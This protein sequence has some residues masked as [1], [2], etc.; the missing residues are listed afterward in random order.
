MGDNEILLSDSKRLYQKL[1]RDNVYAHIEV[2]KGMWHVFQMA[3]FR[4][5]NEAMDKNAEFVFEICR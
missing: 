1:L 5:A 2:F 4:T 3:P